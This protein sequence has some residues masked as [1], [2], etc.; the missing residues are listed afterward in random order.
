MPMV[1]FSA[2]MLR[3]AD[4]IRWSVWKAVLCC[5]SARMGGMSR[6]KKMKLWERHVIIH[7]EVGFL[8]QSMANVKRVHQQHLLLD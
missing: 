1:M 4:G 7:D 8:A 5:W 6:L 2:L 3:K